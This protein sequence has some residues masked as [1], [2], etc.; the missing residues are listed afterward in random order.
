VAETAETAQ[1]D[2]AGTVPGGSEGTAGGALTPAEIERL[3]QK[4]Y[5]LAAADARLSAARGQRRSWP[6]GSRT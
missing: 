5:R 4:V 6:T 3:A 2:A 1:S